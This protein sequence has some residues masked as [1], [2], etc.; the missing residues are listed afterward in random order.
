MSVGGLL[1][2]KV[3]LKIAGGPCTRRPPSK[4]G[5]LSK[6]IAEKVSVEG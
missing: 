6:K 4:G 5:R 1:K 3:K 2:R